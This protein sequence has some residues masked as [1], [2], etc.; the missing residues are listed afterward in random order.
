MARLSSE[1]LRELSRAYQN[2]TGQR[3]ESYGALLKADIDGAFGAADGVLE[4][5]VPSLLT[6]FQA[7]FPA[8]AVTALSTAQ[9]KR[10]IAD[11]MQARL[12]EGF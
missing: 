6:A 3:G 7:H 4:A 10:L 12:E 9:Q 2:E 8:A 1:R 11:V 5:Q